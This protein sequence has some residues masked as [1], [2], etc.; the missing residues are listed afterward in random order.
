MD[1]FKS[2]IRIEFPLRGEWQ[3]PTTPVKRVPSH[4]TNRM[5]MRY[6]FDFVQVNWNK[7]HKPF[8]D[9]SFARYFLS[10]VPLANCYCWGQP[11][12]AP[13]DGEVI[14]VVDGIPERQT[15]HWISDGALAIKNARTFNEYQDD[16]SQIAG[17]Y[18]I[19]KHAPQVYLAFVHLQTNSIAVAV[20]QQLQKGEFLG[21]VGH[22]G[23]STSPHLHFQVMDSD[24]I[25][26]AKG[27]PFV[28]EKYELYQENHWEMVY[29]QLPSDTDRV[30]Y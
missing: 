1:P 22:S 17:N 5:G 20:G 26:H 4:G 19:V 15:V 16:F 8:Y 28:F 30:R 24:D 10:G 3:A 11:I 27:L 2:P 29:D 12:Y 6:A 9:T 7:P 14:A 18:L 23:N 25:A 21:N 13:C